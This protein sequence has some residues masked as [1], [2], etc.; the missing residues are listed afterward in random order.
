MGHR[1]CFISG[2]FSNGPPIG[3]ISAVRLLHQLVSPPFGNSLHFSRHSPSGGRIAFEIRRRIFPFSTDIV[4]VQPRTMAASHSWD[5]EDEIQSEGDDAFDEDMEALRRACM[6]SGKTP[7]EINYSTDRDSEDENGEID[8]L[9]LVR[10]IQERFPVPLSVMPP[11]AGSTSESALANSDEEDDFETLRAIEKR[12]ATYSSDSSITNTGKDLGTSLVEYSTNKNS[13]TTSFTNDFGQTDD[14]HSSS[15]LYPYS[16]GASLCNQRENNL[17]NLSQMPLKHSSFPES[18]QRFIDA[19]KKNRTCQKFMRRKLIEIEAKIAE[20]KQ[21][22]ARIK[23]LMDFQ[24]S[25]KRKGSRILGQYKDPRIKLISLPKGRNLKSGKVKE[26]KFPIKYS[27]PEENSQVQNYKAV[28]AK[29]PVSFQRRHWSSAERESLGKGIKQ[30][31]QEM[32]LQKALEQY[33]EPE[34]STGDSNA[35]DRIIASIADVEITAENMRAFLPQVDWDQL[36]FMYVAGRIGAECEARW[37]NCEDPMIS[38]DP[39]SRQED[40]KLLSIIQERGIYNW[41]QLATLMGMNRTPCQCL[42]RYQR[43]L[44]GYSVNKDWT[45]DEDAQLRAVVGALGEDDWQLIASHLKGRTGRQCYERWLKTL[46]PSRKRVGRWTVDEDKHLKAAVLIFGAKSW[47]KIAGFVPGR[48]QVQCRERWCNVLDPSLNLEAWTEEEDFKLKAAITQHGHCWSKVAALVPPRTDNQCRRRWKVLFRHEVPLVQAAWKIRRGALLTNFVDRKVEKPALSSND[49]CLASD[50]SSHL[51]EATVENGKSKRKRSI[52]NRPDET[53][54]TNQNHKSRCSKRKANA[55]EKKAP[56]TA[57]DL[58]QNKKK[59]TLSSMP[60]MGTIIQ[61]TESGTEILEH[62][63]QSVCITANAD[64]AEKEMVVISGTASENV[65]TTAKGKGKRKRQSDS[66]VVTKRRN[67]RLQPDD[68]GIVSNQVEKRPGKNRKRQKTPSIDSRNNIQLAADQENSQNTQKE[69]QSKESKACAEECPPSVG[70]VGRVKPRR[71]GPCKTGRKKK[72]SAKASSSISITV[73]PNGQGELPTLDHPVEETLDGVILR[74]DEQ[75]VFIEEAAPLDQGIAV[76]IANDGYVAPS[77]VL[78]K[79]TVTE[80]EKVEIGNRS[81]TTR[82][83]NEKPDQVFDI[84]VGLGTANMQV[85]DFHFHKFED[86]VEQSI[87]SFFIPRPDSDDIDI[88][89]ESC[90]GTLCQT[91]LGDFDSNHH[92]KNNVVNAAHHNQ[93]R[94]ILGTQ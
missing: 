16:A 19:I 92:S 75:P 73:S 81:P 62:S 82:H 93:G 66:N 6:L 83:G 78:G 71:L 11:L 4:I 30:Q 77:E 17:C 51:E 60:K 1:P 50:I 26:K 94:T 52:K 63:D 8:D 25:C 59:K 21:L 36:A 90:D 56:A 72:E 53:G 14:C 54:D 79:S 65:E 3:S 20:N 57:E 43:S 33:S 5:N 85:N 27:G 42:I 34:G 58:H 23:C 88:T 69:S 47:Q 9:D 55:C 45:K 12:F 61:S 31:V 7:D 80:L 68:S 91:G 76:T 32:L 38:H 49:F 40:K 2:F 48:T 24:L 41:I 87:A 74:A 70:L 86:M 89:L 13:G 15:H 10:S 84:D 39:W 64:V 35:L 67:R 46:H 44:N 18:A 29:C 37:L 22:M 28:L